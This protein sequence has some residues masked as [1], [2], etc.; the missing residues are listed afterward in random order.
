MSNKNP[1]EIF[2]VGCICAGLCLGCRMLGRGGLRGKDAVNPEQLNGDFALSGRL[3][4]A[5]RVA[6][7]QFDSVLFDYDSFKIADSEIPKIENVAGYLKKNPRIYL[8]IEGHCDER[9]SR[10]YNMSLGERRA[11]AVRAYLIGLHIKSSRIHTKSYGE[12]RP[13]DPGHNE[14]AWRRNR[15]GE[16]AFYR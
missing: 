9:G 7:V 14:Q 2:V 10:E 5:R 6:N 15:R 8:V 13:I 16:F 3:E 12:E 1:L 11:L 4:N